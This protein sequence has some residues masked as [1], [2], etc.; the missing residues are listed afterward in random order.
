MLGFREQKSRT[1]KLRRNFAKVLEL[2]RGPH[3][4]VVYDPANGED[5]EWR[6]D[7]HDTYVPYIIFF[8][9]SGQGSDPSFTLRNSHMRVVRWGNEQ[10]SKY[11]W[12]Q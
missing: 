4:I 9:G 1:A 5:D 12:Y 10:C 2:L 3:P 8:L 6:P 11:T 7:E